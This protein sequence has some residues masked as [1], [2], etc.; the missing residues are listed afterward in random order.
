MN[1][2]LNVQGLRTRFRTDEGDFFA[3]DGMS[4]TVEAGKTLGLVGE[5]G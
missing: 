4:F 2:L 3:V 1:A 5:S